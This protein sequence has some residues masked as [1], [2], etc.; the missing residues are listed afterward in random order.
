MPDA[1]RLALTHWRMGQMDQAEILCQRVLATWPGQSDAMHLLGLMAHQFGNPD[2]AI[3]HLRVACQAPR[4]PAVYF[5][6]LAEMLRQ[7]GLLAEA[8]TMA[9]RAVARD[10]SGH[11]AWNNLG[12]I[13]QELDQLEESRVCLERVLALQPDNA[14]AHNNLGNTCKR[15]GRLEEAE[16]LWRRAQALRPDYAEPHSNLSRLLNEQGRL[17][18]AAEHAHRAIALNPRLADAYVNLAAVETSRARHAE[19]LRWLDALLAFA[20]M[21]GSG[22]A[23]RAL[24]LKRLDRLEEARA[25]AEAAVAANP[26]HAEAHN[27]LGLVLQ[28]LGR[29]DAALAAYER[30]A[31][32]PGTAAE[33]ALVNRAIHFMEHGRAADARAA[34]DRALAAFPDSAL[35]LFNRADLVTF[36]PDEPT[37]ERMRVLLAPGGTQ[38]R[39]ERML[40]HF[41]LG[42]ALLDI[43]DSAGAFHHLHHGNRLKRA[44]IAHDA[45]A[46]G[47]WM[48]RIAATFDRALLERYAGAGATSA[49]PVFVLGMPRS[50]T[51]LVEQIL[52]SHPAIHGAGE[53]RQMRHLVEG[54][55]NYPDSVAGLTPARARALGEAYL[56]RIMPLAEGRRHVVD[57]MP[58]NFLHAGLI[59][60]I[61][62]EAR[63]IHC[64]RHPADTCLSCY[65]KLF[66]DEQSFAY[67]MGELG[68]FHR[69]YQTLMAHWRAVL[70]DSRLLEV[71]YEAV[72][73][74]LEGEARRMLAFL[75]LPWDLA[76]LG[77]HR[78]RRVI[79]TA[80]VAQVRQPI[81]RGSAGRW[82]RHAD[83]LGPL[84]LALGISPPPGPSPTPGMG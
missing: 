35:A 67:D 32:L 52:A 7:Q 65:S 4:A 43:D 40:L 23:S 31:A 12:I 50:G 61:L 29:T 77:F 9:R 28:A 6:N 17:D 75:G 13:L 49:M 21:H 72:V 37:I 54:L 15:L 30:A 74:D 3:S 76:C 48:A 16:R 63:I 81:H 27:A 53:L 39:T 55:G 73:A 71:E 79:R 11:G 14:E 33:K 10:E 78:T 46:T 44:T 22:L 57:K 64:R 58:S 41:A 83:Q 70:P 68:R 60:L 24:V 56:A 59:R 5:S 1:L 69:D 84:L 36:T 18:P 19:A 34:F 38:S 82:R 66:A 80:S 62:P 51:T 20:P 8:E 45:A 2:L 25:S 26:N 47:R 42:K